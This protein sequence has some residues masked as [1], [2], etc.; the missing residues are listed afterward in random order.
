M[1]HGTVFCISAHSALCPRAQRFDMEVKMIHLIRADLRRVMRKKSFFLAP[2]FILFFQFLSSV[3]HSSDPVH[4][5]IV[6]CRSSLN[7]IVMLYIT[8]VIYLGVY[9]D[10]QQ[11]RSTAVLIGRGMRRGSV[12]SARL[13]VCVLC[14]T[15]LY[16]IAMAFRLFF[17]LLA[18][19]PLTGRQAVFLWFYVP[20]LVIRSAGCLAAAMLALYITGSSAIGIVTDTIA[21]LVVGRALQTIQ[22][23]LGIDLYSCTLSG[24]LDSAYDT[25]AVGGL[26]WKLVPAVL[27][28][29]VGLIWAAAAI[30][31]NKEMD[32]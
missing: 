30:N 17:T 11:S 6:S 15:L 9:A 5:Y 2:L 23:H 3:M 22:V 29:V 25:L 1:Y 21:V 26:P 14:S 8:I 24:L 10:N 19:V 16:L 31:Q 7:G 4:Q 27:I 32:L 13:I 28:Y 18:G 20:F 12:F